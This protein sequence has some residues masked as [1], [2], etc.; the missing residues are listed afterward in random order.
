M[1]KSLQTCSTQ[2]WLKTE[3]WRSIDGGQKDDAPLRC[4][5]ACH[6]A[7]EKWISEAQTDDCV[8]AFL[9]SYQPYS[10][11]YLLATGKS[12]NYWHE[13]VA[14][15][16]DTYF[17]ANP[18]LTMPFEVVRVE[19]PQEMVLFETDGMIYAT[20]DKADA[21]VRLKD[22]G[23]LYAFE[24]KTT[25]WL[26]E[27][28]FRDYT[29][30]SQITNHVAC[31][32]ANGDDV[33]GVFLNVLAISKLP[34]PLATTKTGKPQ[35]CRSEGHGFVRDCWQSHVRWDS[36]LLTRS[37]EDIAVW[38]QNAMMAL[39]NYHRVLRRPLGAVQQEGLFGKCGR[40][41]FLRFCQSQRRNWDLLEKRNREDGVQYSG[42]YEVN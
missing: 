3:G 40:C 41:E 42:L 8:Q 28:W 12:A 10:E 31:A 22:T 13:N 5:I 18:I 17:C 24:N 36:R 37:D 27:D 34:D 23:D 32:R 21:L 19:Q 14:K 33:K 6:L 11:R 25:K 26:D 29:L 4:G 9:D 1:V 20:S 35:R 15:V 30:D 16:L 2:A 39:F 38:H 7:F